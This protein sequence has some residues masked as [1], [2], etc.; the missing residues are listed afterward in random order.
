M[1]CV[2]LD[3]DGLFNSN[4]MGW[5]PWRSLFIQPFNATCWHAPTFAGKKKKR[6][7][8][9]LAAMI[10]QRDEG[11]WRIL[12]GDNTGGVAV[13]L[14]PIRLQCV[15]GFTASGL[16]AADQIT[17]RSSFY[18]I[19][20]P[21]YKYI[22]TQATIRTLNQDFRKIP[23]APDLPKREHRA[24]RGSGCNLRYLICR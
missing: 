14:R 10:A 21:L 7:R 5:L 19:W 3:E 15:R 22:Q 8:R 16:P 12:L 20:A 11:G 17:V 1:C 4:T 9:C 2:R 18:C 24:S 6:T 23:L 13:I